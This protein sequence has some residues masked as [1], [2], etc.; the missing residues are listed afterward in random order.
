MLEDS[1]GTEYDVMIPSLNPVVGCFG[2]KR[3]L[4]SGKGTIT[5]HLYSWIWGGG[6]VMVRV[7]DLGSKGP[8]FYLQVCQK[9]NACL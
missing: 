7:S 3:Q 6:G 5:S 9:V 1:G 4:N 8:R 2:T